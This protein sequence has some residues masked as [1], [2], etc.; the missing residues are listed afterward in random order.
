MHFHTLLLDAWGGLLPLL[1]RLSPCLLTL[2][3]IVGTSFRGGLLGAAVFDFLCCWGEYFDFGVG[4][5]FAVTPACEALCRLWVEQVV[6][7]VVELAQ[8]GE[9]AAFALVAVAAGVR[10]PLCSV[11]PSKG[12]GDRFCGAGFDGVVAEVEDVGCGV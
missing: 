9:A 8:I 4:V 7:D 2:L 1:P 12:L 10:Q 6:C 5:W 11:E 3:A